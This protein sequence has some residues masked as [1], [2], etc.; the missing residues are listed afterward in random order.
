MPYRLIPTPASVSWTWIT[1][2]TLKAAV[3]GWL[4]AVI[5]LQAKAAPADW[6]DYARHLLANLHETFR[7]RQAEIGHVKL[8][9]DCGG[10]EGTANLTRLGGEIALHGCEA[11]MGQSAK[12]IFNARVQMSPTDLEAA[13]RQAVASSAGRDQSATVQTLRCLMPGRPNPT[14]RYSEPVP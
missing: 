13:V 9:L 4:N 6:G 5:E 2:V 1:T 11:L 12:L 7:Q 10:R 8:A 14:H 3:L